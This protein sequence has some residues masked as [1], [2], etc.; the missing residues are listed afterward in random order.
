MYH[1][2]QDLAKLRCQVCSRQ[3]QSESYKIKHAADAQSTAHAMMAPGERAVTIL[4]VSSL[5]RRHDL[6]EQYTLVAGDLALYAKA[7]GNPGDLDSFM[8][9]MIDA[10]E[11]SAL[12]ASFVSAKRFLDG[13]E[14]ELL[15]GQEHTDFRRHRAGRRSAEHSKKL[16]RRVFPLSQ[17]GCRS[18]WRIKTHRR[19]GTKGMQGMTINARLTRPARSRSDAVR[20]SHRVR[21]ARAVPPADQDLEQP[22]QRCHDSLVRCPQT[23]GIRSG[24]PRGSASQSAKYTRRSC[25]LRGRFARSTIR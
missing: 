1:I 25:E 7:H 22:V 17:T 14:G 24:S 2:D 15:Y 10:A 16:P 13:Y 11:R 12:S 5:L 6:R 21:Q 4:Q 3:I 23:A 18:I 19:V 9:L 20:D 8:S